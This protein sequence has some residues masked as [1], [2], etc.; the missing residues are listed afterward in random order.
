MYGIRM[1]TYSKRVTWLLR[2]LSAFAL[3]L[4]VATT[5][6]AWRGWG[7]WAVSLG[8]SAAA[9]LVPFATAKCIMFNTP[10]EGGFKCQTSRYSWM[11]SLIAALVCNGLWH[12][13]DGGLT[14]WLVSFP[15]SLL[16]LPI[17]LW[18]LTHVISECD[19]GRFRKPSPEEDMR[20]PEERMREK[21]ELF[22]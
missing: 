13:T 9:F 3:A 5:L 18:I 11:I 16:V 19:K 2:S 21:L 7:P 14:F 6:T 12:L 1:Y 15:V 4:A 8:A 22:S 17:T 10:M 20:T